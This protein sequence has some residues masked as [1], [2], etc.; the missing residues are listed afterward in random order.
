[1]TRSLMQRT[2]FLARGIQK[3]TAVR[4]YTGQLALGTLSARYRRLFGQL[5][6]SFQ[7]HSHRR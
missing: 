1:M 7:N 2:M 3:E 5:F 4:P 6:Q